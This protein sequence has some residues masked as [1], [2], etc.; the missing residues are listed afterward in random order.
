MTK[1]ISRL[2]IS[3]LFL[4]LTISACGTNSDI[5]SL[6]L[7]AQT[8]SVASLGADDPS[9]S[10]QIK[11]NFMEETNWGVH[12]K[13]LPVIR[14]PKKATLL[15]Y[16]AFDNDKGGYRNELPPTL[17]IHEAAGSSNIL[18]LLIESYGAEERDG[19][20]YYIVGDKDKNKV[21]SPYTQFLRERDSADYRILRSSL[22]WGYS[23][24]PSQIKLLTIDNHG[25]AYLGIARDDKSGNIMS[26]PNLATAIRASAGKVDVLS[27]DACL[28]STIEVAYE[29]RNSADVMV[30]SED[31]TLG[32]GMMYAASLP[33]IIAQSENNEDIGKGILLDS[34]RKGTKDIN[35]RPNRKGRIPNV[36][37]ISAFRGSQLGNVAGEINNLAKLLLNKL[38]SQKQAARVALNG[39]HPL[40]IDG[41]DSGGQRDMY[42]VLNRLNTTITDPDI[43]NAVMRTTAAL[44]KA[45]IISR[46]HNSEKYAHGM[47]VNISPVSVQSPEYQGTAFA[48]DT[49]WDEFISAVYK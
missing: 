4:A 18:N 16:L 17:N 36:F 30:G 44:N 45:I 42:E 2:V 19:K 33:Q 6:D 20:R 9:I 10:D 48:K 3:A 26:L 43:K 32:T 5:N 34:D 11:A 31:S 46:S 8:D 14:Q 37:T 24:Y 21:V 29:L 35:L 27:L 25:G 49:L 40:A 15:S 38:A 13:T 28:M 23:N 22:K 39:A 1:N 41:D 12:V 7:S 47:A